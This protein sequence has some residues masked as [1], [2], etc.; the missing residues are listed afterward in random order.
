M[1]CFTAYKKEQAAVEV[2]ASLT[3]EQ[4]HGNKVGDIQLNLFIQICLC[5]A[6]SSKMPMFLSS[7]YQWETWRPCGLLQRRHAGKSQKG[8]PTFVVFSDSFSLKYS[9]C[10]GAIFWVSHHFSPFANQNVFPKLCLIFPL[11]I[12]RK[13]F[14]R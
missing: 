11:I 14:P 13:N 7:V 5:H 10:Q 6:T 4:S 3:R 12:W 8:H 2:Y 9:A 1:C